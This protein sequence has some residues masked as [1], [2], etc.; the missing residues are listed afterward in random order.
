MG[1]TDWVLY[2]N[3]LNT[4]DAGNDPLLLRRQLLSVSFERNIM[5][6]GGPSRLQVVLTLTQ[7]LTLTLTLTLT[8]AAAGGLT[9]RPLVPRGACG[10]RGAR[11]RCE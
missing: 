7:T 10:R 4:K 1:G 3:G 11:G 6:S 8:P 9:P 5:G 2:D